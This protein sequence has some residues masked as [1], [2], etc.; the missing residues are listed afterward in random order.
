MNK[1]ESKTIDFLRFPCSV[2][3]VIVHTFSSIGGGELPGFYDSFRVFFSQGVAR[4]AVPIF[5]FTSGYLFFQGFERWIWTTYK[6]KLKKRIRS[7]FIPYILWNSVMLLLGIFSHLVHG[8][9]S[10]AQEWFFENGGLLCF[11]NCGRQGCTPLINLLG[12]EMWERAFPI[13]YPLWFIRDLMVLNLLAPL[14]FLLVKR[15]RAVWLIIMALLY[16]LNIWIPIEGFR[17]EGFFFYSLGAFFCLEKHG[18]Y[19]TFKWLKSFAIPLA[20]ISLPLCVIYYGDSW[21]WYIRRFFCIC[22]TISILWLVAYSIKTNFYNA[23]TSRLLMESSFIIYAAHIIGI[24]DGVC[25]LLNQVISYIS[26]SSTIGMN[27]SLTLAYI[28]APLMT[29]FIIAMLYYVAK[30]FMPHTC[31]LFSGGRMDIVPK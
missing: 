2:L 27:I 15:L 7:L 16:L 24:K 3:V 12:W 31:A 11:W 17:A 4:L 28:T 6:K 14:I 30:K 10:C 19:D 23:T 29:S 20:L 5:F 9:I 21:Y 18:F 25:Y 22:G 26:P 1:V 8:G 13:N